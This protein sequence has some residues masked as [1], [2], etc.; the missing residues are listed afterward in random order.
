MESPQKP[1]TCILVQSIH[2]LR[3]EQTRKVS[4]KDKISI[5]LQLSLQGVLLYD[6]VRLQTN[7]LQPC[8]PHEKSSMLNTSPIDNNRKASSSLRSSLIVHSSSL[9]SSRFEPSEETEVASARDP[10]LF[11]FSI[12]S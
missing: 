4:L 6:A 7:A 1:M 10:T 9:E 11:G 8:Q 3:L 2:S 12:R 5:L